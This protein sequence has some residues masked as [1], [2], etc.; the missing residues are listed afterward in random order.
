MRQ[1]TF[2]AQ[3]WPRF[4]HQV[5]CL[6]PRIDAAEHVDPADPVESL[7]EPGALLGEESRVLAVSAPVLEVDL[8]VR[9]VPVAA[10]HAPRGRSP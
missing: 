1:P 10:D 6:G 5:Y 2:F 7:G 3:A 9:D 8:L 4:D